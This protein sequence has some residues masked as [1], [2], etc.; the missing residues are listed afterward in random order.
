MF[1]HKKPFSCAHQKPSVSH[2]GICGS[3]IAPLCFFFPP[4]PQPPPPA[5][6]KQRTPSS[7]IEQPDVDQTV[8]MAL[9]P[10]HGHKGVPVYPA[11]SVTLRQF[12]TTPGCCDE[13]VFTSGLAW[14]ITRPRRCWL[15]PVGAVKACLIFLSAQMPFLNPA[16][17]SG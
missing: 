2:R 7:L 6:Q 14:V 12:A 10:I 8:C 16:W 3:I 13:P 11:A 5:L 15:C 4:T 17:C 9:A 1:L